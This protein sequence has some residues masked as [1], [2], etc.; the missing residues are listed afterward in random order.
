MDLVKVCKVCKSFDE[1]AT[2]LLYRSIIFR[3]SHETRWVWETVS[4]DKDVKDQGKREGDDLSARLF[5]R[6]LD[7]RNE[8]LRPL[9]HELTI[10]DTGSRN[11]TTSSLRG[12][13][14]SDSSLDRLVKELPNLRNI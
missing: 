8:R 10:E 5:Y 14:E 1:L 4:G 3:R 12:I 2:A 7:D 13:E 6:L 11:L 9:V